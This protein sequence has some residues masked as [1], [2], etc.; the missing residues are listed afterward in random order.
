MNLLKVPFE[1]HVCSR[2]RTMGRPLDTVT[3]RPYLCIDL[4]I[5]HSS[6]HDDQF[7]VPPDQVVHFVTR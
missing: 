5:V 3:V 4:H 7:R 6:I 2:H 1:G